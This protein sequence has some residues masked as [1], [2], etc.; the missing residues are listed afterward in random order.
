MGD[1]LIFG[2]DFDNTYY[3]GDSIE[4]RDIDAVADFRR[5]GNLF[6]IVTGRNVWETRKTVI[7]MLNGEYDFILCA[8]GAVCILPDGSCLFEDFSPGEAICELYDT[9]LEL[10]ASRIFVDVTGCGP[11]VDFRS[12]DEMDKRIGEALHTISGAGKFPTGVPGED[13]LEF[14]VMDFSGGEPDNAL[15]KR[16]Y[17]GLFGAFA[18]FSAMFPDHASA[19]KAAAEFDR[20][21]AG[22]YESHAAYICVDVTAA[23]VNKASGLL[24]YAKTVGVSEECI[25]TAGDSRNDLQMLRAFNGIAME[26]CEDVVRNSALAAAGHVAEALSLAESGDVRRA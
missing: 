14:C 26:G 19:V 15:V 9:M 21:F 6:G 16:K 24:K 1:R 17:L 3:L 8:N 22:F 13:L 18:Q 25:Y 2:S 20:R 23:G 7:P 5:R 11:G 10:G 12:S 4:Q